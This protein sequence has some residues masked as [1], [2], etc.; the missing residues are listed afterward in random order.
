MRE[1]HD[2]AF[3]NDDTSMRDLHKNAVLSE[4]NT[5]SVIIKFLSFVILVIGII[6]A[7]FMRNERFLMI[8][9]ILSSIITMILFLCISEFLQILHDIRRN[10]YKK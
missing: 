2:N 7:I 8:L 9:L 4:D 1:L 5:M 3:L 6:L 10:L